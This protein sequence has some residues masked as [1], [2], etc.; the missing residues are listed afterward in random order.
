MR[1]AEHLER[2]E[3]VLE[4]RRDRRQHRPRALAEAQVQRTRRLE[5]HRRIA[6]DSG[7]ASAAGCCG[8]AATAVA[9]APTAAVTTT[10]TAAAGAAA[11]A[12]AKQPQHLQRRPPRLVELRQHSAC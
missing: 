3:H 11:G 5:S 9:R 6:A 1:G 8:D 10:A 12:A 7:G 2:A 4:R